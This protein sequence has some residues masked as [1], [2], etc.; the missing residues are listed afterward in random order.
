M[1]KMLAGFSLAIFAMACGSGSI[2]SPVQKPLYDCNT[3]SPAAATVSLVQGKNYHL[4]YSSNCQSLTLSINGGIPLALSASGSYDLSNVMENTTITLVGVAPGK[5]VSTTVELK[6]VVLPPPTFLINRDATP[7]G[8]VLNKQMVVSATCKNVVSLTVSFAWAFTNKEDTA[9]VK[10]TIVGDVNN[11]RVLFSPGSTMP[12]GARKA[13]LEISAIGL[14]GTVITDSMTTSLLVPHLAIDS[15]SPSNWPSG[16]GT[17][18]IFSKDS[19]I[20]SG[21]G[22][23]FYGT[24][25]GFSPDRTKMIHNADTFQKP[26]LWGTGACIFIRPMTTLDSPAYFAN[27]ESTDVPIRKDI[28]VTNNTTP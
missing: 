26:T 8:V 9:T 12:A 13:F 5:T 10:P 24:L 16:C 7:T 15:L 25:N 23:D 3:I 4:D 28:H 21:N 11:C 14:N 18:H 6:V 17:F 19:T 27:Y 20:V 1:L 22:V 2:D